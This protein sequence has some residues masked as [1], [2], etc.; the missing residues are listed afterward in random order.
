ME[1]RPHRHPRPLRGSPLR[2]VRCYKALGQA[3]RA[4]S[5]QPRVYAR[6]VFW[7]R[8]RLLQCRTALLSLIGAPGLRPAFNL[9]VIAPASEANRA[10]ATAAGRV[11]RGD[12]PALS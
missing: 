2:S 5:R 4:A 12:S 8:I 7:R 10:L 6:L 9:E 1:R 11:N 3:N